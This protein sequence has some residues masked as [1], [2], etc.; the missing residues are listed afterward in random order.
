MT[1]EVSEGRTER[2]GSNSPLEAAAVS[3]WWQRLVVP[4][5]FVQA[6]PVESKQQFGMIPS[7]LYYSMKTSSL[8]D[9]MSKS[10]CS[11]SPV[12]TC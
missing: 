10:R 3:K 8:G 1:T 4:T 9:E 11:G 6:L 5:I 2:S 12:I 7:G